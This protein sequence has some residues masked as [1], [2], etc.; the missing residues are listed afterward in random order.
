EVENRKDYYVAT[1]LDMAQTTN[2]DMLSDNY[3]NILLKP[4]E[5]KT[6]LFLVQIDDN[7]EKGY[8]YEFPFKLSSKLGG[9]ESIAIEV[10]ESAITYDESAYEEDM[11][12]PERKAPPFSVM[13]TQDKLVRLGG[14]VSHSCVLDGISPDI[15]KICS[16]E[17]CENVL[18]D[19]DTFKLTIIPEKAGVTTKAHNAMHGEQSVTFFVTSRV[20]SGTVLDI[21]FTVPPSTTPRQMAEIVTYLRYSGSLPSD[22]ELEL[23]AKHTV[24]RERLDDLSRPAKQ[25][26]LVPGRAFR[27]GDNEVVFTVSY[28]DE[29]GDPWTETWTETIELTNVGF[30]DKLAFWTE[31]AW[32][33]LVNIV[34]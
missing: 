30:V 6:I 32:M 2:T 11:R 3:K 19:K 17:K 16:N 12:E 8:R 27:P 28:I 18:P 9:T 15:L 25:T 34:T 5:K 7:L 22:L 4:Y 21:D 23:R 14:E 29:L 1:R 26:W 24:L 13:C 31:D 10:R 20:V 33:F